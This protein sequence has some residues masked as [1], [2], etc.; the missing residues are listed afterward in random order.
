[1]DRANIING[2]AIITFKGA[3]FYTAG[4]IELNPGISYGEINTAMHGKV[5]SF[6]DDIVA[7]I[8]FTPAGQWIAEHLA[9]LF[10]Y[11]TPVIGSSIFGSTDSDVTIQ[12]LA[13]Q[14][15]TWK[16][17]AITKMPDLILSAVK[18][19]LGAVTIA[20]IGENATAWSDEAKRAVVAATAFSDASF[21]PADIKM[22]AYVAAITGA[23]APWD[24]IQ[25]QEGWT[26]SFDVK[27]EPVKTD[28]LGTVDMRIGGVT[29]SAKCIPVGISEAQLLAKLPLQ[30]AGIARGTR[31]STLGA[32]LTITGPNVG[33]PIVVL[34][35]AVMTTGQLKF[36]STAL[37]IGEI[38]FECAVTFTTGV[39]NA[40]FTVGSVPEPDPEA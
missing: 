14:L 11:A 23:S 5:D 29:A 7:E 30:G 37:R 32:D 15:I 17:G 19:A 10:P 26:I 33:D 8:T 1:M 22:A 3:S 4:D 39:R 34:K 2:P 24:A 27:A 28:A 21:D 40:L 25:T 12:T 6:I 36:G 31:L 20:C 35:N 9:V 18:P 38:A 13:G 16:A